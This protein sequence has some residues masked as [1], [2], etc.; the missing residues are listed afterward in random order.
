[1]IPVY[2]TKFHTTTEKGNCLAACVASIFGCD[3]DD[4]MALEDLPPGEWITALERWL[5]LRGHG[6]DV[7]TADPA[8]EL[9]ESF[10]YLAIGPSPRGDYRHCVVYRNGHMIHDPH[11]SGDGLRKVETFWIF[12]EY[13][14]E[15]A[16]P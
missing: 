5:A 3:I 16:T 2:Q 14:H 9:P 6:W 13:A 8:P 12:N 15:A 10:D 7:S 4:V 1:M 11:P